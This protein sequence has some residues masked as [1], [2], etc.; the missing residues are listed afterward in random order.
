M[1]AWDGIVDDEAAIARS[2]KT[3]R[4]AIA[5]SCGVVACGKP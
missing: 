4:A 5:S 3:P 1:D 2:N